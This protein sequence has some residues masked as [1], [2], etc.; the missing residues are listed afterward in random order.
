MTVRAATPADHDAIHLLLTN[1]FAGPAEADLV[2]RLRSAGDAR[3]ELVA[4]EAGSL[5]GHIL[6]SALQAPCR[7]LALAPLAVEPKFQGRGI[8]SSLITQGHARAREDGWEAVFV[9]GEPAYYRRFGY[10]AES[11]AGVQSPYAGPHFM[12]HPLVNSLA[13]CSG[14]IGYPPAFAALGPEDG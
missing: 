4:E 2:R 10:S 3:I 6:F 8:G 9:L 13:A 1:A 12:L 11:A 5:A 14:H 7:A